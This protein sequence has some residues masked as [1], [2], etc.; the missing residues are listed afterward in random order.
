[1]CPREHILGKIGRF[2]A[3]HPNYFGR[4]SS[5][6]NISENHLGTSFVLFFRRAWD[7]VGQKCQFWAK[8]GRFGPKILI[9]MEVS[10][11][12]GTHLTENHRGTFIGSNGPKMKIFF[13]KKM[14]SLGQMCPSWGKNPFFG[15][16]SKTIR[17][18]ISGHQ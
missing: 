3:E 9:F 17:S 11:S 14:P 1:M 7:H 15:R 10:K 12:F 13:A 6:T 16:L 4:K 5:G 2:W 8:Y 18:P